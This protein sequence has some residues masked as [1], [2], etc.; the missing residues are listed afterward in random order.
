M[1]N[2]E[3]GK[4]V[5]FRVPSW[6]KHGV[7]EFPFTPYR[8]LNSGWCWA[9]ILGGKKISLSL[10]DLISMARWPVADIWHPSPASHAWG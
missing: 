2:P 9:A 5:G 1:S 3:F 7:P 8:A 4:M 6:K 10:L